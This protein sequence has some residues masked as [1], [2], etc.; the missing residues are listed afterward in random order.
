MRLARGSGLDGLAAMAPLAPL[1]APM[2]SGPLRPRKGDRAGAPAAGPRQDVPQGRAR[3]PRRALV[4]RCEQCGAHLRAEP[5]ARGW[6]H[7]RPIGADRGQP[8]PERA[9]LAASAR[10]SE[11]AL[12][13]FC[14]AD[15][16]RYRVDPCGFISIDAPAWRA[17]PSDLQVRVLGKGIGAAGGRRSRAAGQAGGARRNARQPRGRGTV[18]LGADGD[19]RRAGHDFAG[20]RA[21][22]P[23]LAGTRPGARRA[24]ALGWP[25]LGGG[26]A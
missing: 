4:G 15:A 14:A 23:A 16:G 5:M 17:L 21:W 22:S 20:A 13:Q 12:A 6:R 3:G 2:L 9:A 11:W 18:D 24:G 8:G 25:L 7:A 1:E 19:P 10:G 26:R